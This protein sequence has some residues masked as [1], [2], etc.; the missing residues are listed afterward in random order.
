VMGVKLHL[1]LGKMLRAA[2]I[3]HARKSPSLRRSVYGS[4]FAYGDIGRKRRS[5][6]CASTSSV[7][8]YWEV[9]IAPAKFRM[10]LQSWN[11]PPVAAAPPSHFGLMV[12]RSDLADVGQQTQSS[13][14]ARRLRA[15]PKGR[16]RGGC[17]RARQAVVRRERR[18]SAASAGGRHG[19]NL[20]EGVDCNRSIPRRR[21]RD[22]VRRLKMSSTTGRTASNAGRH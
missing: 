10:A 21:A 5:G 17:C 22:R 4:I 19:S 8:R 2:L 18:E 12:A 7:D 3:T 13:P 16:L 20:C 6:K 15:R 11:R 14:A 1:T 9:G